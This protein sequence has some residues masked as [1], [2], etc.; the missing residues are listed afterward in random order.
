MEVA[1]HPDADTVVGGLVGALG[2][3]SAL[4]AVRAGKRLALAK[5]PLVVA[6]LRSSPRRRVPRRRSFWSTPSRHSAIHQAMR[7][8]RPEETQRIVLTA[9]GGPFRE[10]R[11]DT[12]DAIAVS[13]AL[14]HPTWEMGTEDH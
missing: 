12:F 11:L 3:R 14:A 2:L 6:G 1:T 8:G 9:S 10:R 5:E 13:D 4:A 7:C